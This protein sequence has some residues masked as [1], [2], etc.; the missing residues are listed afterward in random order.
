M[1]A[2]AA[3]LAVRQPGRYL[4]F[5]APGRQNTP[6]GL[7]CP[8]FPPALSTCDRLPC[9]PINCQISG[10]VTAIS[11]LVTPKAAIHTHLVTDAVHPFER[12]SRGKV[13]FVQPDPVGS[14]SYLP[15]S[16]SK[17]PNFCDFLNKARV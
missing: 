17:P 1:L 13:P 10:L 14:D 4:T 5:T 11:F 15:R 3:E 16:R 7:A 2:R 8:K 12:P 9:E 6:S